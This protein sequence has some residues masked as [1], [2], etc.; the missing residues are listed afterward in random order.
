M[1]KFCN[2][3]YDDANTFVYRL[4]LSICD[5]TNCGECVIPEFCVKCDQHYGFKNGAIGSWCTMC[6]TNG[7][8]NCGVNH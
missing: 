2:V 3:I 4:T 1:D 8:M 6:S 7:C 5:D